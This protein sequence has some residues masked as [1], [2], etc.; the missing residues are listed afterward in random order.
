MLILLKLCKKQRYSEI[1]LAYYVATIFN[2]ANNKFQTIC[3]DVLR[4]VNLGF[5]QLFA[6]AIAH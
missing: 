2:N 1:S 5:K 3:Q 4:W 6:Y